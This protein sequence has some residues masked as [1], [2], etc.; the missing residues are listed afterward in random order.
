[1]S[2]CHIIFISTGFG[3]LSTRLLS[4]LTSCRCPVHFLFFSS[5]SATLPTCPHL[6]LSSR[7]MTLAHWLLA[8]SGAGCAAAVCAA[9]SWLTPGALCSHCALLLCRRHRAKACLLLDL[10]PQPDDEPC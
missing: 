5:S 3:R 10:P 9:C 8:H 6:A 7:M 1:M 4:S 2:V